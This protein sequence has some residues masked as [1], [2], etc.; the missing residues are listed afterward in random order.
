MTFACRKLM[1]LGFSLSSVLKAELASDQHSVGERVQGLHM[2]HLMLDYTR[3]QFAPAKNSD[4]L[5]AGVSLKHAAHWCAEAQVQ[6][7]LKRMEST[8]LALIDVAASRA[9]MTCRVAWRDLSKAALHA[10]HFQRLAT[11][12]RGRGFQIEL[13]EAATA[14]RVSW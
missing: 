1:A 11:Q 6:L 5:L 2:D 7:A 10:E 12:L 4:P 8:A 13:I 14:F 3:A 9:Q